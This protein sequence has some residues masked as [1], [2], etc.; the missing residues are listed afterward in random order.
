[1]NFYDRQREIALPNNF[2]IFWFRFLH[3][4]SYMTDIKAYR[5]LQDIVKRDYNALVLSQS[6]G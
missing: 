3:H 2:L 1:M 5:Q 4:F 6:W